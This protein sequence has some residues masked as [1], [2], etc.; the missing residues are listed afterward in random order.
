MITA[1]TLWRCCGNCTALCKEDNNALTV[2]RQDRAYSFSVAL[3]RPLRA[4]EFEKHN[5]LPISQRLPAVEQ[6]RHASLR[7]PLLLLAKRAG[8]CSLG[9]SGDYNP[10]DLNRDYQWRSARR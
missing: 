1:A 8:T 2:W 10:V 5:A 4:H 7:K 6:E 9:G 3:R